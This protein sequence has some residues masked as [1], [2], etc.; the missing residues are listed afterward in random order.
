MSEWGGG[1][2]RGAS[3]DTIMTWRGNGLGREAHVRWLG[4][5]PET[6]EGW[7]NSWEPI[8]MLTGD[9][10]AGGRVRKRRSR[11]EIEEAER[12]REA[13]VRE[14]EKRSRR[15]AARGGR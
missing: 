8:A 4:F 3:L 13:V 12:K 9:L 15:L 10:Q 7:D 1:C 11:A 14:G 5:N 2:A 6:G